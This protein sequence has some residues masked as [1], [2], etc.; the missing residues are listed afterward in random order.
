MEYQKKKECYGLLA[1]FYI[2]EKRQVLQKMTKLET[3][4]AQTFH[5]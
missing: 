5:T 1:E 2:V 3:V 4:A